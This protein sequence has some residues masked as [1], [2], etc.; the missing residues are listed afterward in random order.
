MCHSTLNI[1]LW[2][3][4]HMTLKYDIIRFGWIPPPRH[5]RRKFPAGVVVGLRRG[6]SV[7]RPGSKDP[8]W[9]KRKF[10]FVLLPGLFFFQKILHGLLSTKNL[11]IKIRRKHV[12][13]LPALCDFWAGKGVCFKSF[14]R[15]MKLGIWLLCRHVWKQNFPCFDGGLSV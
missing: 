14:P 8:H 4:T 7:R 5:V 6:S 13:E 2:R 15:V 10:L 3:M 12:K 11:R 9:R 1:T